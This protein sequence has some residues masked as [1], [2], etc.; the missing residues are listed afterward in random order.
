MDGIKPHLFKKAI[1]KNG[2]P[3][4]WLIGIFYENCVQKN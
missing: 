1:V 3:G 2:F 4:A